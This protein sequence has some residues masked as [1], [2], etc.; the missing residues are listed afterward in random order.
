M[1]GFYL[2]LT[3]RFER[4]IFACSFELSATGCELF[5]RTVASDEFPIAGFVIDF[6]DEALISCAHPM[7]LA[8]GLN[9]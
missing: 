8:Q 6:T 2:E 4:R 5:G 7:A 1:N 3:G 9:S